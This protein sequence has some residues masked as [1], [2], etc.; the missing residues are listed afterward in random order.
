MFRQP[1]RT[2]SNGSVL[3]RAPPAGLA[4]IFTHFCTL[5]FVSFV[6]FVGNEELLS[7]IAKG[8]TLFDAVRTD[9]VLWNRCPIESVGVRLGQTFR[10]GDI[11]HMT[12]KD[13]LWEN[14]AS[15]PIGTDALH[16]AGRYWF[17]PSDTS[18]VDFYEIYFAACHRLDAS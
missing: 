17:P 6:R 2:T 3:W 12:C 8:F 14:R 18:L 15:V 16:I 11:G 10:V 1:R 9:S 5:S 7:T 4:D 13:A